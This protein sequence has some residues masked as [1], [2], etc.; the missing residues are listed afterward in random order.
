MMPSLK[1]TLV[2]IGFFSLV[3]FVFAFYLFRQFV[4]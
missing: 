1:I 2:L 3:W 4:G